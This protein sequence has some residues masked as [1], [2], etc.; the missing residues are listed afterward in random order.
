MF[1]ATSK[2]LGIYKCIYFGNASDVEESEL[3]KYLAEE[4]DSPTKVIFLYLEGATH[5]RKLI[6]E[7]S[8]ATKLKPV[9][10][11]VVKFK[12]KNVEKASYSEKLRM[13]EEITSEVPELKMPPIA[14]T[15]QEKMKN[16][17][18]LNRHIWGQQLI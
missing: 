3:L 2:G 9:I 18:N 11:D 16:K 7:M 8:K 12:G 6:T 15:Q 14:R 5:G 4:K 17:A 1:R 13:L 10:F